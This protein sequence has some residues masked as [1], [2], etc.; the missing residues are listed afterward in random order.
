M[1]CAIPC[2]I[3]KIPLPL[4]QSQVPSSTAGVQH[5]FPSFP[6]P[7]AC[8]EPLFAE[9][10]SS[11][12][13]INKVIAGASAFGVTYPSR[14]LRTRYCSIVDSY[15]FLLL[16][17]RLGSLHSP[18]PNLSQYKDCLKSKS[19]QL[20]SIKL[21]MH[22][23]YNNFVG[24]LALHLENSTELLRRCRKAKKLKSDP[25]KRES[26]CFLVGCIV[27]GNFTDME[28]CDPS[29]LSFAKTGSGSLKLA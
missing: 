21:Y 11:E 26:P 16:R 2:S 24:M 1:V 17:C 27:G 18:H 4:W 19:I 29:A 15:M 9:I 14:S 3:E 22:K 28:V 25:S 13:I 8:T 23:D 10:G 5:Q 6:S 12:L 20:D 7:H